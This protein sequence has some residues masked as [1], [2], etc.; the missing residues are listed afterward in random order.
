MN[1]TDALFSV[2]CTDYLLPAKQPFTRFGP[3]QFGGPVSLA[4]LI[5]PAVPAP[6]G[7]NAVLA[8][9]AGE[10]LR[11]VSDINPLA[12]HVALNGDDIMGNGSA[13]APFRTIQRAVD[14]LAPSVSAAA[15]G[16]VLV[17]PGEYIENVTL[18]ANVFVKGAGMHQ[19]MVTGDW[20]LDAPSFL[21]P[22]AASGWAD[23][24][25]NGL[26]AADFLAAASPEGRLVAESVR[27][28]SGH[29]EFIGFSVLNEFA[30][31]ACEFWA[32]ADFDGVKTTLLSCIS[33][34]AN[35]LVA[36]S[37]LIAGHF[38]QLGGLRYNVAIDGSAAGGA[39]AYLYGS[40]HSTG[41]VDLS[42]L[43][44]L[45]EASV[46]ALPA[47]ANVTYAGGATSAQLVL[48]NDSFGLAYTPAVL[49]DWSGV[50]PA[51]VKEALDRIAAKITPIP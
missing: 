43:N 22:A 3:A 50:A 10:L 30:A 12:A 2:L 49:A 16:T 39:R 28:Q 27:F 46:A 17:A 7:T 11:A 38:T 51:S 48:A 31:H 6:P 35:F 8:G 42:G 32:N 20:A 47:L 18:A 41:T 37:G 19:T 14:F 29:N 4:A 25:L 9:P 36:P 44:C 26:V 23:I 33:L 15:R 21:I 24:A 13:L 40:V 5:P 1:S 45:V 34:G